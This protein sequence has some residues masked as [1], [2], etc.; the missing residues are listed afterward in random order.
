MSSLID[1]HFGMFQHLAYHLDLKTLAALK[2]SCKDLYALYDIR[3][4][5]RVLMDNRPNDCFT[6]AANSGSENLFLTLM[7]MYT[8]KGLIENRKIVLLSEGLYAL[9]DSA[10]HAAVKSRFQLAFD[11]LVEISD[12]D[13]G[14]VQMTNNEKGCISKYPIF[15][16]IENRNVYMFKKLLQASVTYP[17]W[18]AVASEAT[19]VNSDLYNAIKN[20]DFEKIE[21]LLRD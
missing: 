10:I 7:D 19:D 6:I 11:R 2:C 15:L 1:T 16:A 17:A 12:I 20:E 4:I 18:R 9:R 14:I 8:N 3:L 5:T 21:K 13:V